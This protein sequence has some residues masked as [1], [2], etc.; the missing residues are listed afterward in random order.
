MLRG[1]TGKRQTKGER[2]LTKERLISL[3]ACSQKAFHAW[4]TEKASALSLRHILGLGISVKAASCSAPHGRPCSRHCS[5][6]AECPPDAY[7]HFEVVIAA[8]HSFFPMYMSSFGLTNQGLR[9]FRQLLR[10]Q[11]LIRTYTS[12]LV[13][14]GVFPRLTVLTSGVGRGHALCSNSNAHACLEL[15]LRQSFKL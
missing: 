11:S 1:Q 12:A 7:D 13:F 10:P 5:A 3:L 15:D 14:F 2:S 4:M 9:L 8:S 6:A